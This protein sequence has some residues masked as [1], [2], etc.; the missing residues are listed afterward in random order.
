MGWTLVRAE[1][2]SATIESGKGKAFT[3][4]FTPPAGYVGVAIRNYNLGAFGATTS[5]LAV[6]DN[7]TAYVYITNVTSSAITVAPFFWVLCLKQT[8]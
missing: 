2:T 1:A 8:P 4:S 6:Y 3:A 7:N 5:Q